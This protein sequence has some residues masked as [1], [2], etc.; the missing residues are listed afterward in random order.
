MKKKTKK[1]AGVFSVLLSSS[2]VLSACGGQE[3]KASTEPAKQQD[4]KDLK[5]EKVTATDKS[6]NPEKAK[7]R[8][9]T[10]IVGISKPGG[11]FLPYFQENGWDGNVT[12]VIFASL[13]STD[14]QGK[15]VP[16]LAEKWDVSSDQLKYTFHLRKNLKFSD[17]SP[18]TADDVAFTLTLLH[19][20]AYEG[21]TDILQYAIKGGKNYKEGKATSIEGI[22]V[23]NPQT[24]EITTEKVN[25]QALVSLGGPVLSKDYYGKDYKQNT[26]LNYL[27]D[28]Y[29]KPIAA[30]PYKFEKYVPGQEVRFVANEHYYAGKP[31]VKNFI[32][33]ITTPDTNFQLFQTGE[34]DYDGFAANNDNIEQLKSL[35]FANFNIE[36][37]SSYSFVYLNNKKPYLK[38]KKVRQALIYGLDRKKYV[39]TYFQGNASV[40]N[41]PISPTSWAYD[42]KGINQYEYNLEKAKKLLDEAGWKVGSDGIR[43]KDGQKLKLSYYAASGRKQEEV[44]IPIAKENYKALG[45][46]FNP[47]IMDFNT[48]VSKLKK[49]DYDLAAVATPIISD[50]SET[51][52]EFESTHP[53]NSAGYSNPKV[54]E[55]IKK[56]IETVDIEKRKPIYK[57]LYKELSDDPPVILLNYRKS[58]SAHNSRVKGINPEKYDSISSNLPVLSI[59][60]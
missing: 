45:V 60:Q 32:Y 51:V 26:S 2:L 31:K 52:D 56:G 50:P 35:G 30:G 53:D 14:K 48:L 27:K 10:L 54:D 36:T 18:L 29:G 55:L 39:D 3:D 7:Q 8:K 16:E 21:G 59:E 33:K 41:I 1:W 37:V 9:N 24:I 44:F 4:V 23:V 6:K 19:D 43:E 38:D 11:V 34:T 57:E 13:V 20:K 15:P 5:I 58:I 28:L 40:A 49:F 22:K 42:D 25:S 47:E 12:S 17:G 46:E